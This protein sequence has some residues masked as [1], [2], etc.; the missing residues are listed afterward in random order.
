MRFTPI[1]LT[2]K[3]YP[4]YLLDDRLVRVLSQPGRFREGN[5]SLAPTGNWNPV[6]QSHQVSI[7]DYW[8]GR[9]WWW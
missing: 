8:E 3:D 2:A 9:E 5:K 7:I 6:P 4:R 1:Y